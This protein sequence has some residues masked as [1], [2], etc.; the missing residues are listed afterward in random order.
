[1]FNDCTYIEK[2]EYILSNIESAQVIEAIKNDYIIGGEYDYFE[3]EPTFT[4]E[5]Q[6]SDKT[7]I[8]TPI[9]DY[10]EDDGYYVT[11]WTLTDK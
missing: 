3:T 7:I 5:I 1:M 8:A 9:Y 11:G 4:Y 10:Y 2:P 6:C